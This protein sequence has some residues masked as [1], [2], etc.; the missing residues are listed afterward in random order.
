MLFIINNSI[1]PPPLHPIKNS[2]TQ[3]MRDCLCPGQVVQTMDK[4]G[5]IKA[6]KHKGEWERVGTPPPGVGTPQ[7]LNARCEAL[8]CDPRSLSNTPSKTQ[9]SPLPQIPISAPA[10]SSDVQTKGFALSHNI[11]KDSLAL[12]HREP[13]SS[14][15]MVAKEEG[16]SL[17]MLWAGTRIQAFQVGQFTVLYCWAVLGGWAGSLGAS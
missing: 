11:R 13:H 1:K 16:T 12:K 14:C 4:A 9:L 7:P 8:T 2:C 10:E 15:G 5:E 17:W 3:S 6:W